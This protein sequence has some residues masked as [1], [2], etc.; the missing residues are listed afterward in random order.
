MVVDNF[1]A[2]YDLIKV[3][4]YNDPHTEDSGPDNPLSQDDNVCFT[5]VYLLTN[6]FYL[7]TIYFN[8][9]TNVLF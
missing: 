9:Y 8:L 4:H 5:N 3:K 6:Y 2:V 1:R 7:V